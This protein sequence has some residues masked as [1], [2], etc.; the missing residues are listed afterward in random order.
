M[1]VCT[2]RE[3]AVSQELLGV[4]ERAITGVSAAGWA[5]RAESL[6]RSAVRFAENGRPNDG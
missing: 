6:S 2:K 3:S 1:V 4:P 5:I